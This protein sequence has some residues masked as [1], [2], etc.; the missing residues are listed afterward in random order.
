MLCR[1]I[2]G[3]RELLSVLLAPVVVIAGVAGC[4]YVEFTSR[5]IAL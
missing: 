1:A 5:Q 2:A 3:R 4:V